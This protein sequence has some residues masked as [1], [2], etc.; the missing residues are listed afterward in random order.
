VLTLCF[1]SS[2]GEYSDSA[3]GYVEVK[4]EGG[5]CTTKCKM[6]PEHN[7]HNKAYKVTAVIN[8]FEETIVS[9]QCEDC[10]ASQD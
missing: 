8:E 3:V 5:L 2:R 6:T 10:P 1:R 4:R 9:C 7:I